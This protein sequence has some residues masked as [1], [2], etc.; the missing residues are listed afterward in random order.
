MK[1]G[2]RAHGRL[3]TCVY[4]RGSTPAASVVVSKKV[5]KTAVLRHKIRR[6]TYSALSTIPLP[7][8]VVVIAKNGVATAHLADIKAELTKLV[9]GV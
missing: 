3:F 5:A 1:T 7:H 4:E 6:R 2:A 8:N 9:S